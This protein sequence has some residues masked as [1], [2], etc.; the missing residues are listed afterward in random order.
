[1]SR[2][3]LTVEITV[4]IVIDLLSYCAYVLQMARI[5]HLFERAGIAVYNGRVDNIIVHS[6]K[7]ANV[8]M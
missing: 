3:Q 7:N 4:A 2:N 5:R 6:V 8:T 1:M